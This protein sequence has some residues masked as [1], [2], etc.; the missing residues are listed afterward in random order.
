MNSAPRLPKAPPSPQTLERARR[1][2]RRDYSMIQAVMDAKKNK[3]TAVILGISANT[4]EVYMS[5]LYDKL[6]VKD[7]WDLARWGRAHAEA[8]KRINA[9]YREVHPEAPEET[10]AL[11]DLVICEYDVFRAMAQA[12]P[13]TS[14]ERTEVIE[15]LCRAPER[16]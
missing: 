3:E 7:R 8:Q 12:I 11:Q 14:K 9:R 10:P 1:L 16:R 4:V 6:K 15:I 13:F 2:T 5:R